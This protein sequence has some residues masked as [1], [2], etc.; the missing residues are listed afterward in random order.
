LNTVKALLLVSILLSAPPNEFHLSE[1]KIGTNTYKR[2]TVTRKNA[3]EAV[4]RYDGGVGKVKIVDLPE[5]LKSNWTDEKEAKLLEQ[6]RLREKKEGAKASA[7]ADRMRAANALRANYRMIDGKLIPVNS[8]VSATGRAEKH[9]QGG[10]LLREPRYDRIP[11]GRRFG[12]PGTFGG[13][14]EYAER[15]VQGQGTYRFIRNAPEKPTGEYVTVWAHD[16]KRTIN[17]GGVTAALYD[18]GVVPVPKLSEDR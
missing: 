18:V 8:F 4:F 5:P 14:T 7:E 13:R 2:V 1:L 15:E 3:L 10:L 12:I 9:V 11:T 6:D 16:L 17:V